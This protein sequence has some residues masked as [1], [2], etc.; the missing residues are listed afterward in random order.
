MMINDQ[1]N[2]K[3]KF[4]NNVSCFQVPKMSQKQN[5]RV[6]IETKKK[7]IYRSSLQNIL[8]C[9]KSNTE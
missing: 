7:A 3:I 1:A 4:I 9:K 5:P 8:T 2:K 6:K